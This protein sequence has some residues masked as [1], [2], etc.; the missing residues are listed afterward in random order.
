MA[1]VA[2]RENLKQ[3]AKERTVKVC[4]K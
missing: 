1:N 4:N 2:R 3:W